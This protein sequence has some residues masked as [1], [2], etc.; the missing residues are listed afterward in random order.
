MQTSPWWLRIIGGTLYKSFLVQVFLYCVVNFRGKKEQKT[1]RQLPCCRSVGF[2]GSGVV[3]VSTLW[4]ATGRP[5]QMSASIDGYLVMCNFTS[6]SPKTPNSPSTF[7]TR[8]L[9]PRDETWLPIISVKE[10]PSQASWL[11]WALVLSPMLTAGCSLENKQMLT[12]SSGEMEN[13]KLWS[14][15]FL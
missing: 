14:F 15:L 10:Q 11:T 3:L 13:R 6:T 2:L 5:E 4:D 7:P 1:Y 12:H 9:R 8:E